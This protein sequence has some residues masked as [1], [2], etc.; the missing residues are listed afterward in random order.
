MLFVMN[1]NFDK[2]KYFY[3]AQKSASFNMQYDK[4]LC[5]EYVKSDLPIFRLYTWEN[6]FTIGAGQNINDYE[7][8][9][10]TNSNYAKRITGGGVLF[11]GHDVSYS[12]ILPRDS[13]K[14]FKVK[15]AYE[16]ICSFIIEFY[17]SLGL[18]AKL[19][20]Y[21]ENITKT[22]SPFCQVGIEESDIIIDGKKIGGNAQKW[23]KDIL[24]QHGSIPVKKIGNYDERIGYT[25]EDFGIDLSFEEVVLGLKK[26]FIKVFN[27]QL[28]QMN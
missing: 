25:L 6:S 27:C 21:D 22:K 26:S 2:F 7:N 8:I 11:H 24:F 19:A 20:K 10:V 13:I 15:E 12:I 1:K 23:T 5:L 17:K 9:V 28:E 3:N 4:N 18:D 14:D 16:M